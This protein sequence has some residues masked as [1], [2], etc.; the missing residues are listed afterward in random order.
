VPLLPGDAPYREYSRFSDIAKEIIDARIYLG[1]HFH[2]ADTEA[3]S[4]GRRVANHV[5]RS[6]LQ[7]VRKK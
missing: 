7:P 5:F 4:Q 1:I 2:F 6:I 3:R